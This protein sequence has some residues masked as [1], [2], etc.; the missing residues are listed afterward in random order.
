MVEIKTTQLM[1]THGNCREPTQQPAYHLLTSP[2]PF[3]NREE[4]P[5]HIEH[6][7]NQLH[8]NHFFPK[9]QQH[10]LLCL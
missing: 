10:Q 8:S 9:L 4:E 2:S 6:E 3:T 5:F 7:D 1:Q